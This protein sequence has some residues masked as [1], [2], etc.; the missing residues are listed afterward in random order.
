MSLNPR[1][2]PA[3]SPC[4]GKCSLGLGGDICRGCGRTIEEVR[5]WN[6][7][8]DCEKIEVKGKAA[9]RLIARGK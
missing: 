9:H 3:A 1:D 4:E 8:T 5:D 7:L 2:N 6:T